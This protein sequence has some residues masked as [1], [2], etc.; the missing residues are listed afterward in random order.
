MSSTGLHFHSYKKVIDLLSSKSAQKQLIGTK[1]NFRIH[2][3]FS[4]YVFDF[5][6]ISLLFTPGD[7]H[8]QRCK[9]FVCKQNILGWK[10]G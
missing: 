1:M 6:C 9:L 4:Y 2:K 10:T 3:S 5:P 7:C 8:F